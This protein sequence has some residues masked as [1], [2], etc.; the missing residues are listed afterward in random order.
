MKGSQTPPKVG[1]SRTDAIVRRPDA[2]TTGN[3]PV[4]PAAGLKR[5]GFALLAVVAA[6]GA[7]LAAG[8]V[9]LS[10][11][12]VRQQALSEIRSVTGLDPILRG[13]AE[14]SLFPNGSVS[15]ADVML[16]DEK[17]PAL[18]RR[19]ADGAAA[20]L[21][22]PDRPRRDRRRVARA[23]AHRHRSRAERAIE[24][25]RPDRRPG[26]EPETRRGA[27]GRLL[28]NAHRQRHD[29]AARPGLRR[30]RDSSTTSISRWHGRR[31]RR[32]SAPP[33]ASSGTT[34]RSTR[35]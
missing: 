6:G 16:G 20:L 25:G 9:L 24:L 14:V 32:P 8:S 7:L 23:P 31:S 13:P 21:P 2:E 4:T 33:A 17:N 10:A 3:S 1:P 19:A 12:T 30:H 34:S 35:A 18:D 11:D 15:F 22:A 28:R 26:E 5:L 27:A 29:H